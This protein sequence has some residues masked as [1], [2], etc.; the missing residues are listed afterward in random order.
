MPPAPLA[1]AQVSAL[2]VRDEVRSTWIIRAYIAVSAVSTMVLA[3]FF[4][5]LDND[6][7]HQLGQFGAILAA[8][9]AALLAWSFAGRVAAAGIATILISTASIVVH[10]AVLSSAAQ[11]QVLLFGLGF[12]SFIVVRSDRAALRL[13]LGGIVAALYLF[14]EF[15]FPS[16][17]GVAE[18]APATEAA[19]AQVN[20]VAAALNILVVALLLQYRF[21]LTRR[22]LEGAAR[23]GE[24]R[25]TT[26]ELTGVY[27]RR[28][29]ITQMQQW[30][31]RKRGNYAIAL[32][33]L[34]HFKSVN[35]EFGHACGDIVIRD[36]AHA[37]SAHFRDTDMVSRWGGDEFLVLMP[38][39]RHGDLFPVLERLRA[40]VAALRS[41][42]DAH[43]HTV[44][45]SV[46][47]AMGAL[48]QT[49]D[50]CIAAA[51]HALYRAKAEGRNR[52]VAVGVQAPHDAL[53]RPNPA[54]AAGDMRARDDGADADA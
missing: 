16:G 42:C 1:P 51:D 50:E 44:T 31:D 14:V 12:A 38:G 46:G 23:Y 11:V 39:I 6:V 29:V 2:R 9:F 28:P 43:A 34:D 41:D 25:A 27:N 10:V 33:D 47:A 13:I 21:Q 7:H 49:P 30:G 20:R 45:V 36:V 22:I 32:I 8:V 17:S 37:L 5:S 53:G 48:G 19:Y 26:D 15:A 54:A 40:T 3:S 35:D 52:V 18:L 24:L 4:F